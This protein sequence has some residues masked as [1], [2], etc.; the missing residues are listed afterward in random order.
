MKYTDSTYDC[1]WYCRIMSDVWLWSRAF[2]II[3]YVLQYYSFPLGIQHRYGILF[4]KE[5]IY[6]LNI[7]G[8]TLEVYK[9]YQVT[10]RNRQLRSKIVILWPLIQLLI[11]M[12]ICIFIFDIILP[13][14]VEGRDRSFDYVIWLICGFTP[15]VAINDGI[16]ATANSIISGIN[17]AKTSFN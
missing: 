14:A 9:L 5:N 4:L 15:W 13:L 10:L 2:L 6:I 3:D 7:S 16:M 1:H 8:A 11:V 12:V 17:L